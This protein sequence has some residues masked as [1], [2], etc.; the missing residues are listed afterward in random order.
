LHDITVKVTG[1]DTVV[2]QEALKYMPLCDDLP[3]KGFLN[4]HKTPLCMTLE[5]LCQLEMIDNTVRDVYRLSPFRWMKSK[6]KRCLMSDPCCPS[7]TAGVEPY[8]NI[9]PPQVSPIVTTTVGNVQPPPTTELPTTTLGRV[10]RS[11][12]YSPKVIG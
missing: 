4:A 8:C 10:V 6:V 9:V 11:Y 12:P 7:C 5:H 3:S 2:V 1:V